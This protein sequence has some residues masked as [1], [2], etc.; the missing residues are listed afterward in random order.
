M[1][2]TTTALLRRQR[3]RRRQWWLNWTKKRQILNA[4]KFKTVQK[5][6][7]QQTMVFGLSDHEKAC[8]RKELKRKR[9]KEREKRREKERGVWGKYERE[10]EGHGREWTREWEHF[11]ECICACSRAA[12]RGSVW[13]KA[14]TK[15]HPGHTETGCASRRYKNYAIS[16][17]LKAT[18]FFLLGLPRG[19]LLGS[20]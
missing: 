7:W 19:R 2:T 11:S 17:N 16:T 6:N 3:R 20:Y 1:E 4:E 18:L 10:R 5:G 9:E 13:G 14:Q 12:V 15:G 8:V